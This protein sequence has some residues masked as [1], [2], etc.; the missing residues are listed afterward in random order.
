MKF[1]YSP[2]PNYRDKISTSR[3]MRDLLIGLL[4]ICIFSLGFYAVEYGTDYLIQALMI[5]LTAVGSCVLT[6]VVWALVMKQN[7]LSFLKSSFPWITGLILALML[8]ISTHWYAVVISSVV[9]IL[10]GKLVFGGFGQNIFNPAAVGTAICFSAF[11]GLKTADIVTG[12]TPT[13]VIA[14]TYNW[15]VTDSSMVTEL[16]DSVGGL[17][18]LFIGWYPAALGETS[19]LLLLIVGVVL[20]LRKVIDW[21]LPVV[22][23]ATVF[24][25]TTVMALSKGM[26]M[27]YPMYHLLTGGLM[28]G[29]IFMITDPVTTPTSA[30]GKVIYAMGCAFLT[31]IIRIKANLPEGVMMAILI[32][33]ACTPLIERICDCNQIKGLKKSYIAAACVAVLSLGTGAFVMSTVEAA[34]KP[35]PKPEKAPV[36]VDKENSFVQ[37]FTASVTNEADNGDGSITYS[38]SCDGYAVKFYDGGEPNEFDI[39][40]KDGAVVS[41]VVT[42]A[43]DTEYVGDQIATDEVFLNSFVGLTLDDLSVEAISNATISSASTV[44]AVQTALEQ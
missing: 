1:N 17:W 20:A 37:E 41:V 12:A 35:E 24:A 4:V 14:N 2:A 8:P 13:T 38:I 21:R 23:I 22:Y 18:N 28:F 30:A 9:G 27:W 39:T 11:S 31:V 10:F 33:N 36:A 43:S 34:Q 3:I 42:K 25:M 15:C 19:V 6:E 32:M 16:L 44:K 29:A 7:V 40:I 5:L 26:G